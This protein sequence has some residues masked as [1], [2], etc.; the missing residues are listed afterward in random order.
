MQRYRDKNIRVCGK[1]HFARR[2]EKKNEVNVV[3]GIHCSLISV[4][5]E[6]YSSVQLT[7]VVLQG[8]VEK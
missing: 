7:L 8:P 6:V 3:Y 1:T 4:R 5:L 2:F